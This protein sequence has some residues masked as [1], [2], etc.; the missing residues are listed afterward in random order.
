MGTFYSPKSVTNGLALYLDAGNIKSY[1][2]TGATW[3]D[4]S[5][6]NITTTLYNT[7]AFNSANGGGIVF[8]G[9]DDIAKLLPVTSFGITNRFTIEVVCKP[10][11]IQQTGMFNFLGSVG[12]R[13]IMCHWP[14]S[15]GTLYFDIFD[16]GGNFY[17]WY[18]TGTSIINNINMFH[19]YLN[20][21]GVQEVRQNGVILT[22]TGV[23]GAIVNNVSLGVSNTIGAFY[24]Y[25]GYHWPGYMYTFKVYNRTLTE[26]EMLQNYNALKGRFNI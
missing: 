26:S 25:G 9:V 8:D 17:R 2:G 14:W 19:I 1:P 4:L 7:P 21:S 23:T 5:T 15:D 20:T 18:K 24:S 11:A 13:G 16:T 12:D 3:T 22:P 6:S 10:T